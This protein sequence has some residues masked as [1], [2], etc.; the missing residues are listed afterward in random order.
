MEFEPNGSVE[1]H[2]THGD[3]IR[4]LRATGFA[5]DDL[6]EVQPGPSAKPGFEF[7]SPEWAQRWPSE[8]IW[9]AHKAS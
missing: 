3:W 7:V 4:L 6:I 2:L 1:F 9:V 5:I 8:E